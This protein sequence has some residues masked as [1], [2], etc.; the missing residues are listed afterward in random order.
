MFLLQLTNVL[1]LDLEP[2]AG[3][4]GPIL[5]ESSGVGNLGIGGFSVT[6][7]EELDIL[8]GLSFPQAEASTS[9]RVEKGS[10]EGM[11]IFR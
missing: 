5:H 10:Q 11:V 7:Q 3:S 2:T 9:T 4:S 8:G 6:Q 1:E